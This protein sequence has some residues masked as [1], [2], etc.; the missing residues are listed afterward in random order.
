MGVFDES[1]SS[2]DLSKI[3][4]VHRV[5]IAN[6]IKK[7]AL[8]AATTPGGRYKVSKK[9]LREFLEAK[10]IAVPAFLRLEEKKLAVAVD[11][12]LPVLKLYEN[13]FSKADLSF[14]F[15]LRTFKNSVEAALY[16][17]SAQPDLVLWDLNM[18]GLDGFNMA[19]KIKENSP[20]TRIVMVM[21]CATEDNVEK[22]KNY[23]VDSLMVKPIDV[24]IL[25]RTINEVFG[26]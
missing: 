25:R 10:G 9:D 14:F 13:F 15:Q 20:K 18:P 3:L 8:K 2:V 1:Y 26:L 16:I 24:K 5:T 17:G 11:D 4:G 21:G 6:W 7:G 22:L 19:E 12:E 23:P